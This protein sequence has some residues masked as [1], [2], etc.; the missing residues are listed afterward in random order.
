M[1][2]R[3]VFDICRACLFVD[4]EGPVTVSADCFRDGHPGVVVAEDTAVF[5]VSGRI[6]GDLAQIQ[7]V[8][9]VARLEDH[10]AVLGIQ[11]FLDRGQCLLSLAFLYADAGKYA[12][13]LRL[14]E[15][16]AF[17]AFVRTD[18][19]AVGVISTDEPF[20][21]PACGQNRV[22]HCFDFS[23]RFGSLIGQAA[24]QAELTVFF[25][26]LD[27]HAGDEHGFRHRAFAG[28]AGLEGFSWSIG[29]AVQIQAVVPVRASDQ[30]QAVRALVG[31][32]V[33][34]GSCEMLEERNL[35]R[36]IIV[37]RN[38]LIKNREVA[39]LLDVGGGACDQPQRVIV[40]SGSDIGIAPLGERLVLMIRGAVL[41]LRRSNVDDPFARF[42]RDQMDKAE[43]ILVGI[44]EAHAPADT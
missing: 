39:R 10:N 19:I 13:A 37:E 42:L 35:G 8:M 40:E 25:A 14:D 29:E 28:S 11:V 6:G 9:C 17:F 33:V 7:V 41:K 3:D 5:F 1:Y 15:D 12:E 38:H 18:D 26:V 27:E 30:R 20:A 34:K 4:V 22:I 31:H 43:K 24:V 36:F 32:D 23:F 2:L 16:L 21:V 44:T